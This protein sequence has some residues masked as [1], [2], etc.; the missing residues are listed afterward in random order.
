MCLD[1]VETVLLAEVED[2]LVPDLLGLGTGTAGLERFAVLADRDGGLCW[3]SGSDFG[4]HCMCGCDLFG[5]KVGDW[6]F[7]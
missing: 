4:G 2:A 1:H 7:D 6:R 3:C 5:N